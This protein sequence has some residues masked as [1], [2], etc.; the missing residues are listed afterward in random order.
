MT[1]REQVYKW[2]RR[3]CP[4]CGR[5]VAVM[6]NGLVMRHDGAGRR[7]FGEPLVSCIGSLVKAPAVDGSVQAE[8]FHAQDVTPGHEWA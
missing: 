1:R 3:L 2:P 4:I 8:L 6:P 5:Q 7:P